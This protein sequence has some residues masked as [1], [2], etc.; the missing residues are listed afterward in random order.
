MGNAITDLQWAR[1]AVGVTGDLAP[2]GI[3]SNMDFWLATAG[4]LISAGILVSLYFMW[5][6][7]HANTE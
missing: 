1:K 4:T 5:N 7:R 6:V 2:D 3:A